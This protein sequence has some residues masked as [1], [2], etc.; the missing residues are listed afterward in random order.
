MLEA[1][2]RQAASMEKQALLIREQIDAGIHKER[3]RLQMELQSIDFIVALDPEEAVN[4]DDEDG[5]HLQSCIE[6]TN[7]GRSNAFIKDGA[8]RLV[9]VPA[10]TW[11]LAQVSPEEFSPFSNTVE[12][13]VEPVYC[14]VESDYIYLSLRQFAQDIADGS[15]S[16]YLY[17]FIEYESLNI[18]WRRNFGYVWSIGEYGDPPPPETLVV[19]SPPH[20]AR[21]RFAGEWITSLLHD[22]AE[23]RQGPN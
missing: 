16:L 20:S 7:T 18:R 3:A 10:G 1:Y 15:R 21:L 4:I 8:V 2:T 23:Y 12:P 17:G 19:R 13:S 14:P 9:L 11:P 6:L 5:F 22:N